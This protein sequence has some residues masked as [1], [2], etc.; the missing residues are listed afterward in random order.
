[1]A[2]TAVDVGFGTTI[3][4]SSGFMAKITNVAISGISR[5]AHDSSNMASTNGWRTFVPGDLKSPG[6]VAVDLLFDKN[7][8]GLKTNIAGAAETI[9]ITFPTHAGGSS[10]GSWA[11]SGFMTSFEIGVP[12]DGM[13]T[14][15]ANLQFS[16]EPT[17]TDGS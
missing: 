8:A 1:M 6:T 5:N 4:F 3:T 15:K 17:G 10:G 12:M 16:G 9:T 7:N 11:A 13:M 14:A 2:A